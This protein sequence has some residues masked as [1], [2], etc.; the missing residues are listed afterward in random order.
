MSNITQLTE[1]MVEVKQPNEAA[2]IVVA[3][4]APIGPSI[5]RFKKLKDAKK[6]HVD[7]VTAWDRSIIKAGPYIFGAAGD[8][9]QIDIDMRKVLAITLVDWVVYDKFTPRQ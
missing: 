2:Q 3:F 9:Y 5:F 1:D 6:V 4:D 8:Q 7:I